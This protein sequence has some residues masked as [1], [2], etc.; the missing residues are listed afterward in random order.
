MLN[1]KS[2][3]KL[4]EPTYKACE[5]LLKDKEYTNL[6]D[7]DSHLDDLKYDWRNSKLNEV[8]SNV[9]CRVDTLRNKED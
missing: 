2:N 4:E 1:K 7:F 6:Y 5:Q 9:S 3:V 8:I